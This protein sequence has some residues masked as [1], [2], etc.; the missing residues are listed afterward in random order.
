MAS[1]RLEDLNDMLFNQMVR[2]DKDEISPEEL[3]KEQARTE[4][5][6]PMGKLILETANTQLKGAKFHDRREDENTKL[7][8]VFGND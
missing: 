8:R 2:L 7:P 3:E 5:M 6:V 1:N 4:A